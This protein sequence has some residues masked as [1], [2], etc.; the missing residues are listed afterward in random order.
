MELDG[1]AATEPQK[2]RFNQ[3]NETIATGNKYYRINEFQK[4]ADY[5][6][7][8]LFYEPNDAKTHV[9]LSKCYQKLFM[10]DK[11]IAHQNIA[12]KLESDQMY[13]KINSADID[14]EI[15]NFEKSLIF[16]LNLSNDLNKKSHC[17]QK[18]LKVRHKSS[19][20]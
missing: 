11:S 7:I 14:F 13:T 8:A 19:E 10:I 18:M 5:Y 9:K 12:E 4:A 20:S 16:Y 15:G 6:E 3:V 17:T 2:Q 1:F